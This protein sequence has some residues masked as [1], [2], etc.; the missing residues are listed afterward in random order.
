MLKVVL[1]TSVLASA[2]RSRSGA[3][4]AV[5]RLVALGQVGILATPALF[6]EY[7]AVL[8]RDEQRTVSG[9]SIPEIDHLLDALASACLPVEIHFQWRPQLNDPNDEMVLDTAV[10]SN[11]D[12]LVTFNLAHFA[13]A[14]KRFGLPLWLPKQLLMEV[15]K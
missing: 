8:K 14:A 6:W 9:L 3:S 13:I 10:N 1:D 11:A 12:A 2:L 7:E 15:H 4:H 5:L